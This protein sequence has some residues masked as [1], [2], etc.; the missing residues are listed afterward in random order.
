M[1]ES[2]HL[3][4]K[5]LKPQASRRHDAGS[6]RLSKTLHVIV[7]EIQGWGRRKD[8]VHLNTRP[9]TCSGEA[10]LSHVKARRAYYHP[11]PINQATL[12]LKADI[13]AM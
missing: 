2:L 12:N 10:V 9:T 3:A 7:G 1:T 5:Q 11:S 6:P 4:T 13:W 8:V